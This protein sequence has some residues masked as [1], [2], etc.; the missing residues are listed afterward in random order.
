MATR[1]LIT[2]DWAMK[3][4]LRSKANFDILEGFLSELLGEDITILDI[5]ESESNQENKEYK[6]NRLDLKVKNSKGELIIIEVQYEREYDYFQRMLYGA[7]RVITEHQKLSEP[8]STIPTV[9]SINILY[10]TLG[11][12]SDYIYYGTTKFVGMHNRD[13]LHLSKEQREKYGKREVSDIYPKYYLLQINNFNNVAK[14]SLDEWIYFLKNAEIPENFN[15]KGIKKAKESF[16]FISM[17]PEEQEAFLSYQDALRDQASY[18]ETTYEIPFE[19]GL[20]KG[21]RKGRKEGKE[22]GLREGKKLGL[23]EGVLKGKELGLQ[24]GKEL[25]LQEGVLKGKLE[26]ARKLMAK[27]MSAEE[28]AGIAGVNIGLLERND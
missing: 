15:A 23:Q 11:E 6:Y 28:A 13:V 25:G 26:I 20:K 5:L 4:L 14:T 19:Q 10:F 8:Y 1:K 7:S 21:I 12:G 2:F 9:I 22:Q 24:E 17:T 27:G 3:R 16:D 18:F